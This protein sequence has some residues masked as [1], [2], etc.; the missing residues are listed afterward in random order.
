MFIQFLGFCVDYRRLN[1]VTRRDI[2]PLPPIDDILD[3]A[4]GA[5]YFT[6]LDFASG[7]WQVELEHV[8]SPHLRLIKDCLNSIWTLQCAPATFQQ[9]MQAI[10]T[11]WN[12]RNEFTRMTSL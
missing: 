11:C 6:S 8:K 3:A 7:Y 10:Y 4:G 12:E 1:A 2:Y 5:K 9:L